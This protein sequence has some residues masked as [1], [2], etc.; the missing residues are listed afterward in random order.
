MKYTNKESSYILQQ[1][2]NSIFRKK[3]LSKIK[4][5]DKQRSSSFHDSRLVSQYFGCKLIIFDRKCVL[6]QEQYYF[7]LV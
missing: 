6:G 1:L 2:Y 7:C 5:K 4:M 3:I